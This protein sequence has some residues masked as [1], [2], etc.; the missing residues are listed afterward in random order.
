MADFCDITYIGANLVML[1]AQGSGHR[2]LTVQHGTALELFAAA[3]P[4]Y[5]TWR[6]FRSVK[7]WP[8]DDPAR[9]QVA[10]S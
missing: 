8:S 5:F 4:R 3:E 2:L 1:V 7:F 10:P 6:R 9:A